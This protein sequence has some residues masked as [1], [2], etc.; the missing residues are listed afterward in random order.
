M[1]TPK[2]LFDSEL[3]I[4]AWFDDSQQ[5]GGWF[6][7]DLVDEASTPAFA[8]AVTEASDVAS[9]NVQEGFRLAATEGADVVS[10]NVQAGFVMA[11]T[12]GS[13]IVAANVQEGYVFAATEAADT[14]AAIVEL[15][16]VNFDMAAVEGTD[17]AA[18]TIEAGEAAGFDMVATEDADTLAALVESTAEALSSGGSRRAEHA[19]YW[20]PDLPSVIGLGFEQPKKPKQKIEPVKVVAPQDLGADILAGLSAADRKAADLA[21]AQQ[22]GEARKR[23]QAAL[24]KL[25]LVEQLD[26]TITDLEIR[27]LEKQREAIRLRIQQED[28]MI[29]IAL[30][31]A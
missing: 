14:L 28:E 19:G 29:M 16:S 2:G 26:E 11:A 27:R 30:L 21:Q 12:E 23:L 13:D 24:D 20:S 8:M 5:V 4:A 25:E 1:A 6:D 22:D 9:A 15:A 31:A 17:V 7:A 18:A 3:V 10:A